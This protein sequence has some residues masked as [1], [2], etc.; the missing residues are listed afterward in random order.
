MNITAIEPLEIEQI[1]RLF[2][3]EWVL[4]GDPTMNETGIQVLSGIV[5]FHSK[6][7]REVA[8]FGREMVKAY[9]MYT[10]IFIRSENTPR[11]LPR[12]F[13]PR[14]IRIEK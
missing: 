3:D 7:K 1:K 9:K 11:K 12:L 5:L 14:F 2:P 10:L 13:F 6:D 8:Y 4:I